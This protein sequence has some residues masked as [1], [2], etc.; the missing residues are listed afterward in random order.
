MLRT[1]PTGHFL[2]VCHKHVVQGQVLLCCQ[3]SECYT[4]Y[5]Y[6]GIAKPKMI[7]PADLDPYMH[8][9]IPIV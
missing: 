8:G 4:V 1:I 3:F 5:L 9:T 6:E 2:D 7:G